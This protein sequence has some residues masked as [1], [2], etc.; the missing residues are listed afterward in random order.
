MPIERIPHLKPQGV[1]RSE[2]DR[3]KAVLFS[4]F[5][6]E[7][8]EP[9]CGSPGKIKLIA[10]LAGI[11]CPGNHH[12]NTG[13]FRLFKLPMLQRERFSCDLVKKRRRA[14]G[15]QRGGRRGSSFSPRVS[16]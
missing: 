6:E 2:A 12:R 15:P 5:K 8:P 14:G 13:D 3:Q 4:G 1:P 9:F 16:L 11:T 7:V 10:P